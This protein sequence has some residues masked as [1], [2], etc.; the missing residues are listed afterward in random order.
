MQ[1]KATLTLQMPDEV[2]MRIQG[3]ASLPTLIY[4]PGLHGNWTLVGAFRDALGG[5]V[6]FV[7]TTYPPTLKWSLEDYA[8]EVEATLA[9]HG[10]TEG[11]L[12]AESFS[13]QIAWPIIKRK[14]FHVEGLILAG[15]FVQ[16]P[17]RW[18]VRLAERLCGDISF[19]L[20]TRILFGYAK[21]SRWRF[22]HSPETHRAI[23]DF[24]AH[25]TEAERQAAKHRLR[26][27]VQNDACAIASQ[28]SLPVYGLTGVFDPVVPWYWVR[29]WLK[30][31]CRALR[32]YKI[33]W[34]ADHNVLGTG[35]KAAADQIVHW[36]SAPA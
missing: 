20:L 18:G 2:Q 33:I 26:L 24:I 1:C 5:R 11:W 21:V 32:E 19:A 12:L 10:I 23:Q 22:R 13:S 6:R 28:V 16:H 14:H 3:P 31:N 7:E 35:A 8:A 4:L 15:G 9:G 27:V 29:R 17:M 36:I 30:K 25:L 34:H